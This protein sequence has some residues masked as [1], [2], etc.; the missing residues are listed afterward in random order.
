VFW[1]LGFG[2]TG[3]QPAVAIATTIVDP[4]NHTLPLI[5][6]IV[7]HP[8]RATRAPRRTVGDFNYS[9]QSRCC[10]DLTL[11]RKRL[12]TVVCQSAQIIP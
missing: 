6:L 2:I 3:L 5:R 11:I 8:S 12:L 9:G 1:N 10:D 4:I 7:A